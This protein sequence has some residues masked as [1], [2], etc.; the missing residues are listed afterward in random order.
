MPTCATCGQE[1]PEGFRFCGTGGASLESAPPER[2]EERKVLTVLYADVVST[3]RAD[4]VDPEDVR[5]VLAPYHARVR[6]S[7]S[8]S[9][10]RSRSS[11]A[12]RWSPSSAPRSC[13]RT[14]RSGQSAQPSSCRTRSR[15]ERRAARPRPLGASR[16][17]DRRGARRARRRPAGGRGH[18]CRR[19][20]EH[21]RA[22]Q[23]AAPV[24]GVLV[25]RR[26][27]ARPDT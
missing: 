5:A 14:T 10:E 24:G 27:I 7:W 11:S 17:R 1:S 2:R 13:T 12:M 19:R 6:P 16:D 18:R 8:G 26:P 20:D 23:A 25:A 3:A 22:P 15:A 9:A 4:G 21:G